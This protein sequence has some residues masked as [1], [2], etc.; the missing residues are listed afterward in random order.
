MSSPKA[1]PDRSHTG[2]DLELEPCL[3]LS[4]S[5]KAVR[6]TIGSGSTVSSR[7]RVNYL[8]LIL[9]IRDA[10]LLGL[11]RRSLFGG[12]RM[13]EGPPPIHGRAGARTDTSAALQLSIP[14]LAHVKPLL[15][16][17]SDLRSLSP[18]YRDPDHGCARW[19]LLPFDSRT[20]PPPPS[21]PGF[22]FK[23]K[24]DSSY[25]LCVKVPEYVLS[26]KVFR[27]TLG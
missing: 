4:G 16:T 3:C 23:K 20:S 24:K 8:T 21:P 2:L 18:S 1:E 9:E 26:G 10:G 12:L 17:V 22:K 14:P 13:A 11:L 25:T 27:I 15:C 19:V 7:H 5:I 6:L